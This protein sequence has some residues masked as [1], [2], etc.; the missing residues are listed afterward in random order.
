MSSIPEILLLMWVSFTAFVSCVLWFVYVPARGEPQ[1]YDNPYRA[2]LW[3]T[4]ALWSLFLLASLL[5]LAY[6]P[7]HALG[8]V[9]FLASGYGCGALLEHRMRCPH[10][11]HSVRRMYNELLRAGRESPRCDRC[12]AELLLRR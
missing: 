3:K 5:V 7:Y 10:C 1:L 4:M 11:R 6:A 12:G 2:L 8:W 9:M